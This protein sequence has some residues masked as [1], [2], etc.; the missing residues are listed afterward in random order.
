MPI[1]QRLVYQRDHLARILDKYLDDVVVAF[2]FDGG[3]ARRG[4]GCCGHH[5]IGLGF[6]SCA[7]RC[8]GERL[9][10]QLRPCERGQCI[11]RLAQ[12]VFDLD[13]HLAAIHHVEQADHLFAEFAQTLLLLG[14][15]QPG[16]VAQI[17]LHGGKCSAIGMISGPRGEIRFNAV[18]QHSGVAAVRTLAGKRRREVVVRT[19]E[20][21]FEIRAV[22][23]ESLD[24]RAD[25]TDRDRQCIEDGVIRTHPAIAHVLHMLIGAD[26]KIGGT[27]LAKNLQCTLDLVQ[28][29]RYRVEQTGL[30]RCHGERLERFF[31]LAEIGANLAAHGGHQLLEFGVGERGVGDLDARNV[32]ARLSGA[33]LTQTG[34]RLIHLLLPGKTR[35]LDVTR[36]VFEQQQRAGHGQRQRLAALQF[37]TLQ[38]LAKAGDLIDQ[39]LQHFNIEHLERGGH[40]VQQGNQRLQGCGVAILKIGRQEV[41]GLFDFL[42][43]RLGHGLHGLGCRQ[44][45]IFIAPRQQGIEGKG[46]A[47]LSGMARGGVRLTHLKEHRLDQRLGGVAQQA[48]ITADG[49]LLELLLKSRQQPLAIVVNGHGAG[50]QR[51]E[52]AA[53][54]PEQ[55]FNESLRRLL[56]QALDQRRQLIQVPAVA[57][58]AQPIEQDRLESRSQRTGSNRV[59]SF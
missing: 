6:G 29:L 42:V 2:N 21:R 20:Q 10:L 56:L 23:L 25:G 17:L 4:G 26:H 27:V 51:V 41:L 31:D 8:L 28:G 9:H 18:E 45:V 13:R 22:A 52:I 16:D 24:V 35:G 53:R 46:A 59:F 11:V 7:R 30:L 58:V 32:P 44:T 49:D 19:D 43:E 38:L 39:R 40:P 55:L 12:R 14:A 57:G 47:H 34:D 37:A 50:S 33:P 3:I 1:R 54:H 48:A 15:G 36:A 5:G